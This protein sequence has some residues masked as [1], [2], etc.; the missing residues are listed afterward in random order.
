MMKNQSEVGRLLADLLDDLQ[1]GAILWQIVIIALALL[2]AWQVAR[3]LRRRL[4]ATMAA[5]RRRRRW[6][7]TCQAMSSARAMITICHRIAPRC[8]SSSRSASKRPTSDWFFI[9]SPS[10]GRI[11]RYLDCP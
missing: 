2:I 10:D 5:A 11:L 4:A 9:I 6:R 7:A 8:R 3:H 1:R